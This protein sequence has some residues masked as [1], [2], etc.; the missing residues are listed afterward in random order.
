M[1]YMP[2]PL[3]A[4][5]G[6]LCTV[7]FAKATRRP[8]PPGVGSSLPPESGSAEPHFPS[9]KIGHRVRIGHPPSL[10]GT[11]LHD[12]VRLYMLPAPGAA[13]TPFC[14]KADL[15]FRNGASPPPPASSLAQTKPATG[16]NTGSVDTI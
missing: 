10:I 14:A 11:P 13:H 9:L 2:S 16:P 4:A 15:G 6:R 7:C 8:G 1:A 3:S 5:V 12:R